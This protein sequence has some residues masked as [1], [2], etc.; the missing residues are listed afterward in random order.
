MTPEQIDRAKTLRDA[1]KYLPGIRKLTRKNLRDGGL[2]LQANGEHPYAH[3][4][5]VDKATGILILNNAEVIIRAELK[6]LGVKVAN[7]R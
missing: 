5:K 1:L 6:K 2:S 7:G 4:F 3:S